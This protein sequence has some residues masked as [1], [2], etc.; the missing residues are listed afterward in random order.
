MGERH[1]RPP[2]VRAERPRLV[3]TD[4]FEQFDGHCMTLADER[5][6]CCAVIAGLDPAIHLFKKME[7]RVKPAYDEMEYWRRLLHHRRGLPEQQLALF[8][9]PDRRL[10]EIRID[11][12]GHCVGAHRGRPLADGL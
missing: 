4:Q 10:A 12:F 1:P 5:A 8:L 2:A 3:G 7:T 11:L 6:T 9:G